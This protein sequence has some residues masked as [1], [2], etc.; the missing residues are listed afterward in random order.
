MK[1]RPSISL[2]PKYQRLVDKNVASGKF[3]SAS[4][5]IEEALSLL[6]A[7]DRAI[8]TTIAGINAG[9][10]R[11][12]ADMRAGRVSDFDEAAVERIKQ[13]GRARLA[14]E[15]RRKSA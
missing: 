2:R 12:L 6:D 8:K 5:V 4:E 10:D 15:R 14:L 1:R 11:G 7:R 13:R 3:E 9:I